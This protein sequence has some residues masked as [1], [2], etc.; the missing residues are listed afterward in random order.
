MIVGDVM[1]DIGTRLDSIANLNVL[2]YEADDINVPAG[3]VSLPQD[4]NYL[5]TYQRGMDT[6]VIIVTIL[7]SLVDDRCRRDEVAPYADGSGTRSVKQVLET[8]EYTAFDVITVE[9]GTF[10]VININEVEYL[11]AQFR[12]KIAGQGA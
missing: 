6:M 1:D 11:A 3:L 9:M 5:G 10:D 4:I 8:G 7:V 2:P 12:C